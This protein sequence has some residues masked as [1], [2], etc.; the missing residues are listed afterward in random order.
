MHNELSEKYNAEV[1]N[2]L[3]KCILTI[4]PDISFKDIAGNEYAKE[5]INLTF[6][7]P[8]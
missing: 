4:K 1:K 2:A 5:T 3:R 7:L 8:E 6:V